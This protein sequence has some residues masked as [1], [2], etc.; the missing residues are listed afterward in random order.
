MRC[1]YRPYGLVTHGARGRTLPGGGAKHRASVPARL[2]RPRAR[3]RHACT[4][5]TAQGISTRAQDGVRAQ[6]PHCTASASGSTYDASNIERPPVGWGRCGPPAGRAP[7]RPWNE[8]G[9]A[10]RAALLARTCTGRKAWHG[11]GTAWC[12]SPRRCRSTYTRVWRGVVPCMHGS[13]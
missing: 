6:S 13:K 1:T 4:Q 9:R 3:R 8:H 7:R 2:T 10:Q 5:A 11:S 12:A